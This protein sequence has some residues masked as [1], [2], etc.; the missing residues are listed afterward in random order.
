MVMGIV[1]SNRHLKQ[2]RHKLQR[3]AIDPPMELPVS[4]L[5][6]IVSMHQGKGVGLVQKF[7]RLVVGSRRLTAP[8]RPPVRVSRIGD[9]F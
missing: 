9:W 1:I 6:A 3:E 4:D 5:R 8:D 2:V 7:L